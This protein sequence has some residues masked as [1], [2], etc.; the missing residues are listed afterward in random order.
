MIRLPEGLA[1][2]L[3]A[4]ATL[5]VPSRQ[6]AH[7]VRLAYAAR[8]LAGGE[9]VWKS[10]D[11]LPFEAWRVREHQPRAH[12]AEAETARLL[13][14][15]EEWLLW[16]EAAE[17]A[18]RH[19]D[20]L[21]LESLAEGLQQSCARADELAID[22]HRLPRDSTVEFQVLRA[23][24]EHFERR[25]RE[26]HATRS[27][28][29]TTRAPVAGGAP[30]L[31]AGFAQT[32]AQLAGAMRVLAKA[33]ADART[34]R[35]A[36]LPT[37]Q[38]EAEQI[39]LWCRSRLAADARARLL[40]VLPGSD[41]ARERLATLVRQVLSPQEWLHPARSPD[42]GSGS[43]GRGRHLG[44]EHATAEVCAV[45]IE[46]GRPLA[47]FSV[48]AHALT[49]LHVLT[50]TELEFAPVSAWLRSSCW[51]NGAALA[52]LDVWLRGSHS[53]QVSCSDWQ[54]VLRAV[55]ANLL[56]A[57][58]EL[59]QLLGSARAAL[60]GPPASPR[61]WSERFR[62]AL[63]SI[64]WPGRVA[65]D[66]GE[67]QTLVRFHELLDEFGQL[68]AVTRRLTAD[69]AVQL[70]TQLAQRTAFRPAELDAAVTVSGMWADPIVAYDGIW[71]AGLHADNFP[72]PVQPDSFIPLPAQL[73]AG[74]QAASAEGRL[75]EA[76]GLLRAWR[77][78]TADLVLSAPQ[79]E[80]DLEL[81]HSPLLQPWL[82]MRDTGRARRSE[83]AGSYRAALSAFHGGAGVWLAQRMHRDSLL[84]RLEDTRGPSW[85]ALETLPSG[86][87]SLELQNLCA[88]RAYAELRLGACELDEPQ[89]GVPPDMRGQLLHAALD[90]LWQQLQ[91]SAT[92]AAHAPEQLR[93]LIDSAVERAASGLWGAQRALEPPLVRE[94]RRA[95]RLIARLCELE[96][97]RP[98]FTVAAREQD[99]TAEFAGARLRLRVDRID[100]LE[101]GAR[102]ILDYKS[103]QSLKADWYGERPSH[104]Q[105]LAYLAALL[106]D[107]TG[108]PVDALATVNITAR[109]V[110]FAGVAR[111]AG[112]LPKVD[113]VQ[114]ADT[115]TIGANI[116]SQRTQE[117]LQRV[118]QLTR[119]FLAG[120]AEVDPKE[121]A[122]DF[123]HLTS[124]CRIADRG[125]VT[126]Q[127]MVERAALV[128]PE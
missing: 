78:S 24:C 9:R 19:L 18:A 75:L 30:L 79:R 36:L 28:A 34:P 6:R 103:G 116:W 52:R 86:T 80:G 54:D 96:R 82:T 26:L 37:T 120:S 74:F 106:A 89:R 114:A 91:D 107:G 8:Q 124:L 2:T 95:A 117:W 51:S 73:Q 29:A 98:P 125:L 84:E 25:C 49:T 13:A 58:H 16:R 15:G 81:L 64:G 112:L 57:A 7:A 3:G 50:G 93:P 115:A 97:Q 53:T 101:S 42:S 88:F 77:A 5:V 70:L 118:A 104:P 102:A 90:G 17:Q 61:D 121:G 66:S 59:D 76:H 71:V 32:P 35:V 128:Q 46:G 110:R 10:P 109:E 87:R 68:S 56:P 65:R 43:T 60:T 11:V 21:Q 92:L 1:E 99:F 85:S 100:R 67:Q 45:S 38:D 55:P 44:D 122:C 40:V 69:R 94:Q 39:A 27:S 105:L 123:C 113:V 31:C 111:L 127:E 62:T 47:G 119:Q 72:R 41:G 126:V 14:P 4:G 33:P 108:Q 23:A 12:L 83:P 20:L 22:L 63:Q 48:I